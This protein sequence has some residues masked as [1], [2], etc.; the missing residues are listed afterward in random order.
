MLAKLASVDRAL[1]SGEKLRL[2]QLNLTLYEGLNELQKIDQRVLELIIQLDESANITH[3]MAEASQIRADIQ[4]GLL[5]IEAALNPS[6]ANSQPLPPQNK[7]KY[8]IKAA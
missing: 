2:Q 3:E 4:T 6:S 7:G 5:K 1:E 8:T